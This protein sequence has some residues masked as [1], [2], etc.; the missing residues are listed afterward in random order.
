MKT[1][2]QSWSTMSSFFQ[3]KQ[4]SF[5][6]WVLL[7]I[8][9]VL[10]F[11]SSLP[12]VIALRKL[13]LLIAFLI[14]FKY[15]WNALLKKPKPQLSAVII[16][17][18][19]Q[20]WMLVIAGFISNQP[21]S[22]FSEWKGQWLPALMAFVVGIGLAHTLMQAKIKNARVAVAMIISIPITIFLCV[23]AIALI[24]DQ[25]LT[26]SFPNNQLGIT[27]QKG[28]TNYLIALLEP[29]VI[30]DIYCRLVKGNRLLPVPGW[31][32]FAIFIL[33]LFSLFAAT[34]RNGLFIML[35]TLMLGA[36]M[37]IEE[38]RKVYSSKKI[39]TSAI[40]ALII[41]LAVAFVSY[42]TDPR[43]QNFIDTVHIAWD[44]DHDLRWLN[45]DADP[46]IPIENSSEYFRIA[47]AH[48]GLRMLIAHPWGT[49]ISR[50][51][52]PKL[53]MEKYGHAKMPQSENS[54]IDFGLNVG[55]P[56]LILWSWFLL[57]LAQ[58][59]WQTWR[60]QKEPLSLALAVMVIMFAVRGLLDT[61]FRDHEL[62]Q[63]MMVAGL[64]S[65]TLSFGKTNIQ[66]TYTETG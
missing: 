37:M 62:E 63:F 53:E 41:V 25:I 60:I 61:I 8:S 52:F 16:F 48:E 14:S 33:A 59:G 26:G 21:S 27:D 47:W 6:S 4:L 32:I 56:G 49:E 18:L 10:L 2:P 12:H 43:W 42:K 38:I 58:L 11:I 46:S 28:I 35:L 50:H 24:Y 23:N 17:V 13:L 1:L 3:D 29:I 64:L 20:A 36:G 19:L 65:G 31:V 5:A 57:L 55:I 66:Q 15:F 7:L 30:A 9:G 44:I 40:A 54:W 39:V 45:N 34:S 51:T 22:S